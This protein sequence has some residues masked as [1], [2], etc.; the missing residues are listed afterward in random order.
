MFLKIKNYQKGQSL[1]E[2]VVGVGLIGIVVSALAIVSFSSLRNTQFSKN[3]IQ[4]TKLAQ[5]HL[6][7]V[8]TIKN[9]N[10]GVCLFGQSTSAC[11]TWE[12]IWSVNFGTYPSSCIA[13][14]TYRI[15]NS[16]YTTSAGLKNL[17]LRY[18]NSTTQLGTSGR[19]SYQIIL[20]DEGTGQK[21]ATSLVYWSDAS[22]QHSSNLT[23][24]FG[25]Y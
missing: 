15:I 5:E 6:E 14:C 23:T 11:S 4:A 16:C 21:K 13:G 10:L 22:G 17:C 20:E 18:T 19:F 9:S 25:R 12:E 1:L 8:R 3:Q 2:L 7:I 24:V